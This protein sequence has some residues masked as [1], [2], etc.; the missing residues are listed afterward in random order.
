[1]N[2]NELNNWWSIISNQFDSESYLTIKF[3]CYELLSIYV[4]STIGWIIKSEWIICCVHFPWQKSYATKTQSF[5]INEKPT[6]F[7]QNFWA[8]ELIW[9]L[10]H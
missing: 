9:V 5:F 4:A 8:E 3:V 2:M 10:C 1:M 6:E 7:T